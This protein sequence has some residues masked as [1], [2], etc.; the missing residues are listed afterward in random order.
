[1]YFG[2]TNCP[3]ECPTAMADIAAALRQSPQELREQSRVILITT[4]P[5]RD[6]PAV[7][8]DWIAK[9]DED[10][11]ALTG[12]ETETEAAQEAA[13]IPVAEPEGPLPALPGKPEEHLHQFGT[14]PHTHTGPLG[15]GVAHANVIF[16][17]SADDTLPVVYPGG[18]TAADMAAD[19]PRLATQGASKNA[20][21]DPA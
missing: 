19:L 21:K 11:I 3:D 13:G 4:D 12:S 14:V 8:R 6:T 16:A 18:V 9:F 17:Y 10:F 5:Q 7:L 2:Y 20:S 15:Y 1:M